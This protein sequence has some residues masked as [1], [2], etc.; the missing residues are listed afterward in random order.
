[1][2]PNSS[3]KALKCPLQVDGCRT[4][5]FKVFGH[6]INFND[7][8]LEGVFRKL[9]DAEV[10]PVSSRNANSRGAAH[11]HLF[12]G[13]PHTADIT[14]IA[15]HLPGRQVSLVKNTHMVFTPFDSLNGH[16]CIVAHKLFSTLIS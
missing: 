7:K 6:P 14:D 15:V 3:F 12:H 8:A 11:P 5:C 13:L 4:C 2:S 1:M 16:F 9:L 10:E